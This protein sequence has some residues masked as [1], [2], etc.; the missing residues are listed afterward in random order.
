[1]TDYSP[2]NTLMV[3]LCDSPD[4]CTQGSCN[5]EE[6]EMDFDDLIFCECDCDCGN[7]LDC[8]NYDFQTDTCSL[9][10]VDH[11]ILEG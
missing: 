1:M 9:D 11:T 3:L 2:E 5:C 4:S 8:G 6:V 7:P 10:M